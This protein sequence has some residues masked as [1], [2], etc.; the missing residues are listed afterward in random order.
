MVRPLAIPR[1]YRSQPPKTIRSAAAPAPT[2][3]PTAAPVER[4]ALGSA[5]V[6]V[7]AGLVIRLLAT[8]DV[9]LATGPV[10]LSLCSAVA[11]VPPRLLELWSDLS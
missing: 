10:L 8:C 9:L 1:R 6:A 5:A 7:V 2:P 3:M 4:P 11:V